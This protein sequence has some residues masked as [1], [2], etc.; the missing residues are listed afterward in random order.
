MPW[1]PTPL[2]LLSL[3]AGRIRGV[4]TKKVLRDLMILRQAHSLEV[5][6]VHWD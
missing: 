6:V 2:A 1:Q 3:K 5:E 4:V